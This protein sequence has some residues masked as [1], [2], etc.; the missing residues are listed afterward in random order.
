VRHFV[1]LQRRLAPTTRYVH[2]LIREGF[3]GRLRSA[4]IHVS[5]NYFQALRGRALQWT[6]PP[7]NASGVVNIYAGHFLD[8]LFAMIGRPVSVS[9]LLVNQF[10]E[11]TI[12]ET[13]ERLATT[14]PDVLVATGLLEGGGVLSVHI[15]GGKRNGSGV[16]IDITG[17]TGDIQ[18]TNTSAFGGI[19]DDYV[20]RGANGDN[21]PLAV[22]PVP[23][24]YDRLPEAELPSA[25]VELAHLY[26]AVAKDL[27]DG[28]HAAPD[29]S[30]AA[31]MHLLIEKF[32]YASEQGRRQTIEPF[33]STG[34]IA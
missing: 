1:G 16:Q 17:H 26:A 32:E 25:V 2:D 4:R 11:V 30:D 22:M 3:V 12:Q 10:P 19:G 31:W 8:M 28:S 13:G 34:E 9:A 7:G 14:T 5:M 21:L 6:V 24:E 27:L 23:P 20:V 29:F 33:E 18:I 15:E